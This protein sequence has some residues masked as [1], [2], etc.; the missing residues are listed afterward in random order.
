MHPLKSITIA[1]SVLSLWAGSAA[2]QPVPDATARVT[3]EVKNRFRLFREEKDFLL[4][5]EALRG[6]TILESEDDLAVQS[7][8]R[9]WARNM[10]NRLCIDAAGTIAESCER[11]G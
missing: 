3:W 2:A 5:V 11:D 10:V 8:G 4:H 6:Q 9:G 7:E 1:L